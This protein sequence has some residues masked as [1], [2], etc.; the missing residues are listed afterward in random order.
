MSA[1]LKQRTQE[2]SC[3][4]AAVLIFAP[5]VPQDGHKNGCPKSLHMPRQYRDVHANP[6]SDCYV[7][8]VTTLNFIFTPVVMGM[9][10]TLVSLPA[11]RRIVW[12]R[13]DCLHV[14]PTSVY[15]FSSSSADY[16]ECITQEKATLFSHVYTSPDVHLTL[17]LLLSMFPALGVAAA[18]ALFVYFMHTLQLYHWYFLPWLF[19]PHPEIGAAFA[20]LII[21]LEKCHWA[22]A[23]EQKGRP[24]CG[25]CGRCV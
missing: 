13:V 25:V 20:G 10:L 4:T 23:P 7:L 19:K 6:D 15:C 17:S 24:V 14:Q 11:Q 1:V 18:V 16:L 22:V 9:T 12:G 2:E 5:F 8:Q 21:C 3:H